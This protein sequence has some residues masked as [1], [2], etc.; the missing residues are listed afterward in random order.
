MVRRQADAATDEERGK[1]ETQGEFHLGDCVN[2]FRRGSLNSQPADQE[3]L[4]IAAAAAAAAAS[5]SSHGVGSNKSG[6]ANMAVS[7]SASAAASMKSSA[8]TGLAAAA[9]PNATSILC[10]TV[11]GAIGTI[12]TLNHENYQFFNSLERAIRAVVP[13]VGGLSHENWRSFYNERR[14]SAQ[15]HTGYY[16]STTPSTQ[17]LPLPHTP[18]HKI[19]P[20]SQTP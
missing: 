15:R 10:G 4:L 9:G 17:L 13:P 14:T 12:I 7:A 6:H 19:I 8:L 20:P 3:A 16:P 1:M 5:S 18:Q 11:S 2:V